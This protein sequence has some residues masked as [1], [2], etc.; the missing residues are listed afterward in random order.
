MPRTSRQKTRNEAGTAKV[1]VGASFLLSLPSQT[2]ILF[3]LYSVQ[4]ADEE[5]R[6]STGADGFGS[7]LAKT[8]RLF[9]V[10]VPGHSRIQRNDEAFPSGTSRLVQPL[11]FTFRNTSDS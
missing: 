1:R 10:E 7:F 11:C 2:L 4:L 8:E 5:V 6:G 9:F 3:H